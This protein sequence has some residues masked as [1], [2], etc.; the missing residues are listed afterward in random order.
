MENSKLVELFRSLDPVEVQQLREF[1]ASP[2]FN[3]NEDLVKLVNYLSEARLED[4]LY[5]VNKEYVFG[6]LFPEIPFDKKRLG[7]LMN[8]ALKLAERYLAIRRF[9]EKDSFAQAY[10]LKEFEKRKLNKHYNFLH[11][12]IGSEINEKKLRPADTFYLKLELSRIEADYFHSQQIRKG[13]STIEAVSASLDDYYFFLKLKYGCEMLN[14]QALLTKEYDLGFVE[15]VR[16]HLNNKENLHPFIDLYLQ[17]FSLLSTKK[18]SYFENIMNLLDIH[19]GRLENHEL[20]DVY[21]YSINFSLRK[22][23]T[24]PK[25]YIDKALELYTK[26]IESKVLFDEEALSPFTFANVVKLALTKGKFDWIEKF[27]YDQNE[28][29]IP[30]F[31]EDAL[32]YSLADLHYHKKDYPQVFIHINQL[33][34]S[35]MYYQ[36]GARMIMMKT[37]YESDEG[38]AL[39]SL[40]ASFL[41]FLRRNG[42]IATNIKKSYS[43]FCMVM[44][45]ILRHDERKREAI[46]EQI[47]S[48]QPL[49]ERGWLLNIWKENKII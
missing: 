5:K 8:Y 6:L 34:Y 14:R 15:K 29:I 39:V 21:L 4:S 26:G 22:L 27:I 45:K 28:N 33:Q 43:N 1:V 17:I 48:L 19:T 30:K 40:I 41:Q 46:K 20:R 11:K 32:H 47:Q 9:E 38:D 23:R 2:Y 18:E 12:K 49:A 44:N 16:E 24:N 7:Y 13:D 36:L 35:D 10:T 3:K 25:V 42:Q 31:R 37:Y